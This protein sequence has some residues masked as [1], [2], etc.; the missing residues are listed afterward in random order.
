MLGPYTPSVLFNA[1]VNPVVP[2]PIKGAIWYQGEANVGRADQYARIFPAMIQN[3][4]TAWGIKDFPFYFVQIA[5]YVYS[6][7]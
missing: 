2:Y 7:D 4:R 3:W 1:M 5:P 6:G